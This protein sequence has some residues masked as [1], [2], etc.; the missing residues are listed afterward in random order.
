MEEPMAG[1]WRLALD[2]FFLTRPVLIF[3][4]WIF[5]LAGARTLSGAP[6]EGSLTLLLLQTFCIFGSAFII[7]QLHDRE[8][9]A[10]NGK[11]G[12][13]G[14]GLVDERQAQI[15]AWILLLLGLVPAALLGGR[16]LLLT[17]LFFILGGVLYNKPPLAAKDRPLAGPLVMGACYAILILQGAS[18]A[19]WVSLG[20]ALLL[21]APLVLAGV[22]ISLLTMIPDREGDR[23]AGKR[24]FVVVHGVDRSWIAAL[25]LMVLAAALALLLGDRV[26]GL[27][28]LAAAALMLWGLLGAPESRAGQVAR[29]SILLQALALVPRWPLFGLLLLATWF[30]A[31]SYYRRRFGLDYPR[32]GADPR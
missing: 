25:A 17:L 26:V 24:S 31:R 29:A 12:T 1:G 14:Q 21:E 11:C 10:A 2:M 8:G 28:A 32:L 16:N 23:R 27:P 5:V 4:V 3:T 18:L 7:N 30:G 6:G 15:L 13:L 19:G 9:D 22:S 20:R